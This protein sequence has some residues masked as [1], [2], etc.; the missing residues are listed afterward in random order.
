MAPEVRC[1]MEESL[2]HPR[3]VDIYRCSARPLTPVFMCARFR[4]Y[5]AAQTRL[6]TM[7]YLNA[8]DHVH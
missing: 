1:M 4:I 7:M 6:H 3:A 5:V 8:H 2:T